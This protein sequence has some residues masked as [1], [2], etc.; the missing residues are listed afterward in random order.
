MFPKTIA[1]QD[2]KVLILDQRQL[3]AKEVYLECAD[4]AAVTEAI[5]EMAIRGAP[6]IGIAA[7]MGLALGA[8]GITETDYPSFYSEL[9]K[10]CDSLKGARPTA[11][12]LC[13][14]L[15]RMQGVC[16]ANEAKPVEAIKGLLVAEALAVLEQDIA[17]NKQIGANGAT[18]VPARATILTHCNAGALATGGYGTA[19]GV[20]RRAWED[21][22]G[23]QVIATETRPLLQGARLTCWELRQEGIP[24][25]L[26]ADHMAG[27]LMRQGEIDLCIV[28]ADRIAGNGDVANKIGTYT[29]A[30][31][32]REH[33]IPFYV[34]APLS[35]FD[36]TIKTGEEIPIEER[37]PSEVTTLGGRSTAPEGVAVRNPAF[38]VTPHRY[39]SAIVTEDGII[40]PP[41]EET[42]VRFRGADGR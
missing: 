32:A 2:N 39:I 8:L 26:I 1:W 7:A 30:I 10:I 12:N 5:K 36:L 6:A 40:R 3:P 9:N 42:L 34:A 17:I 28:G 4:A 16:E 11:V 25:T 35:T 37:D 31:L 20:I 14:A 19:L 18:L 23:I 24:V 15:A 38:D 29:L 27:T 22:K 41:F 33:E 13:W 21:K